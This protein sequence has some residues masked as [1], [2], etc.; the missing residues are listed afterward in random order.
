MEQM[1][2]NAQSRTAYGPYA[3]SG[4]D[5]TTQPPSGYGSPYGNANN[6]IP[7]RNEYAT[8]PPA[9]QSAPAYPQDPYNA[10]AP[11][12]NNVTFTNKNDA[13]LVTEILLSLIGIFG[14]GWIM[15]RE[16]T[17]GV[18]LLT[19]SFLIYWPIMILGTMFT[20]GIG[21]ICL[22]PMAIITIIINFVLLNNM[23]NRK[24][25]R[26]VLKQR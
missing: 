2:M 20:L 26:I 22:G 1:P 13:A 18:I 15:A 24:A 21:L 7:P 4:I 12:T 17:I 16:T 9:Y 3:Q 5:Q 23:L 11:D 25:T 14:V 10:Y 6:I 19:C 8:P